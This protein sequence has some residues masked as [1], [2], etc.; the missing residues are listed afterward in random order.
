MKFQDKVIIYLSV[1]IVLLIVIILLL[2]AKKGLPVKAKNAIVQD[3]YA[4]VSNKNLE[5]C[6]GLIMYNKDE[7]TKDTLDNSTKICWSYN[8]LEDAGEEVVLDKTKKKS[9]CALTDDMVFAVDNYEGDVCT[10]KKIS[11]DEV[12]KKYKEVFGEELSQDESFTLDNVTVC[13]YNEDY[14]YCGLSEKYTYIYGAEPHTYRTIKSAYK[15]DDKLV[16]Y[17]YFLRII[18]DECY[19]NYITNDKN[20]K[21][22]SKYDADKDVSYS[23]MKKYGTVYKHT[24]QKDGDSYYWLS[25]ESN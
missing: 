12:H 9:T 15:K 24:F 23:F 11:K 4:L 3:A 17:D 22:T 8:L 21:C 13:H 10:V 25:S 14:Y 7:V 19:T 1:I 18:N 16:I 2:L 5:K 6:D 20:E